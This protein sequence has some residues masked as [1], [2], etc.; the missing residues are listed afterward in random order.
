MEFFTTR[1]RVNKLLYFEEYKSIVSA[2]EKEKQLKNLVRR[3]KINL[4]QKNNPGWEDLYK[5]LI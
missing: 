5:D 2:I 1:Y 3:K 4:I